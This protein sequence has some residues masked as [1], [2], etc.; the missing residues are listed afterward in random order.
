MQS[1]SS[2]PAP[3]VEFR[4]VP[5][6]LSAHECGFSQPYFSESME[7][8]SIPEVLLDGIKKP[9][10]INATGESMSPTIEPGDSLI[11]DLTNKVK[12]NQ[13]I[14]CRLNG[15]FLIKIFIQNNFSTYLKCVNPNFPERKLMPDDEFEILG[16]VARIIKYV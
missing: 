8:M 13:I 7:F 6:L 9:V 16:K 15:Q 2:E 12:H 4:N 3:V 5:S 1:N 11:I 10:F 14:S